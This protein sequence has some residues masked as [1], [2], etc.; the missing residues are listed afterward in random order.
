MSGWARLGGLM[1][2]SAAARRS[3]LPLMLLVL[4]VGASCSCGPDPETAC[5]EM[6]LTRPDHPGVCDPEANTCGEHYN[7][8]KVEN[9]QM[10]C[11]VQERTCDSEAECCPG[12]ACPA[13]VGACRDRYL[14]CETDQDC[15]DKGDRTCE[16]WRDAYGTTSRCMLQTCGPNGQ[17]PEGQACFNGECLADLPCGG[18]CEEG[19][20]CVPSAS[21]D[22]CQTMDCAA[23]CA[24][25]FIAT[26]GDSRNLWDTCDIQAVSCGCEELPPLR[27]TDLGRFSALAAA[28]DGSLW[29]STYDGEYG[30]LVVQ[31]RDNA[32]RVLREEYVDGLP[33]DAPIR[34][35]P[36]G[37][38]GGMIEPGA[39][40]GRHT[41]IA[42][43]GAHV[44]VSYQAMPSADLKLA[45][46]DAQ[47]SW[48][49]F[50]LDGARA[51][52]GYGTS[53]AIDGQGR[54]GIAYF[55]RGGNA[56]FDPSTCPGTISGNPAYVTAL[57][58]ARASTSTPSSAS[59]FEIIT[60]ACQVRPPPPC[61]DCG[62]GEVC[63]D[64]GDGAACHQTT[65]G[66]S[67]CDPNAESCVIA[68]GAATC[69]PRATVSRLQERIDGVGQHPA[70][71]FIGQ[72]AYVTYQRRTDGK[73]R[74]ELLRIRDSLAVDAP[75]VL[76]ANGDTGHFPSIATNAAGNR[77]GVAYHD[78]STRQLRFQLLEGLAAGTPEIVDR[79]SSTDGDWSYVG[80][81]SSVT[82]LP[83]GDVLLAYQN[84]TKTSLQLAR[85]TSS[86]SLL[87]SL[88]DSGAVG[89]FADSAFVNGTLFVSHARIGARIFGGEPQ[90]RNA[91]LLERYRVP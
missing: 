1:Q 50:T 56:D 48:D 78:F 5:A 22:R 13:S 45:V 55:Q 74:L 90:L 61:L 84:A 15:G 6:P 30:D 26:V 20:A 70:L 46:R 32:G 31:Q 88:N 85:R 63:A 81:D 65:T 21:L 62:A 53:M 10:C 69:A 82:F 9:G 24:P 37:P 27:S 47:G 76:D 7:C 40:V 89:F 35:G 44:F 29:L 2:P 28:P 25:G 83:N 17:C 58:F 67:A 66:C 39:D 80:T 51:D 18:F 33:E 77:I 12:Q 75:V 91:L 86:W 8:E 23:Q 87:P 3:S 52:L 4:A 59:D 11:V 43:N 68:G 41:A 36:S 34:W 14:A 42:V 49:H 71:T 38:R 64:S 57:K 79:G 19:T 60:V 54:L 72:D 73:G 16:T